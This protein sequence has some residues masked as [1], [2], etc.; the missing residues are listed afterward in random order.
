MSSLNSMRGRAASAGWS[1]KITARRAA[2]RWWDAVGRA[3]GFCMESTWDQSRA[4][5]GRAMRHWRCGKLRSVHAAGDPWHRFGGYRWMVGQMTIHDPVREPGVDQVG[6]G[7]LPR[8][9][10][11]RHYAVGSRRRDELA[12]RVAFER[13]AARVQVGGGVDGVAL[14]RAVN[15]TIESLR[16]ARAGAVRQDVPGERDFLFDATPDDT[17][18]DSERDDQG[19]EQQQ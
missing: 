18:S 10:R 9:L 2:N 15:R 19:G 5:Y 1:L 12:R 4:T 8:W 14:Q 13:I 17:V 11:G 16:A 3:A 6:R 7:D